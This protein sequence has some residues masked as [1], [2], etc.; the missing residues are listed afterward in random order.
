MQA[1]ILGL[2]DPDRS[3][4]VTYRGRPRAWNEAL[5]ALR[6]ALD[7]LKNPAGAGLCILT[8]N[9]A[10]PTLAAQLTNCSTTTISRKRSGISTSRPAAR[11]CWKARS[12]LSANT[13]TRTYDFTKADSSPVTGCRF[14]ARRSRHAALHPRLHRAPPRADEETQP[15]DDVNMNRLYAVE[16]SLSNTGG[17][18]DHRLAL[19]PS[20]IEP[21]AQ[22]LAA[23]LEVPDAPKTDAANCPRKR[24]RWLKP[25]AKDLSEHAGKCIV[26]AGDGQPASVHALVHAI[27]HTLKNVGQTVMYTAPIEARPVDHGQ[28]IAE[29]GRGD[30]RSA[31]RDARHSRRQ[32]GLYGAGRPQI[33]RASE[34]SAACASIWDCTRTRRPPCA[35]GTFRRRIIWRAGA[36][37][38]PTTA[39]PAS[40]NR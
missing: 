1:S 7:K 15:P 30:G 24:R 14:P 6:S 4:A 34:E 37:P 32:S 22:A 2:Y 13:S 25:L 29:L 27:N 39:R 16:C 35:T 3:Q 28:Q 8:E 12:W 31:R 26:L 18:A 9:V 40:F 20:Q 36:T 5:S 33:R 17:V 23:E 21:F 19:R 10:S 38:A 11:L